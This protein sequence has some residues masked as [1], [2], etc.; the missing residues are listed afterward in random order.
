MIHA[1]RC[2]AQTGGIA[3]EVRQRDF[4]TVREADAYRSMV[5]EVRTDAGKHVADGNP[6]FSEV[7]LRSDAG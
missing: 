5:V 4:T 3:K 7:V 6:E 2:R 1:D